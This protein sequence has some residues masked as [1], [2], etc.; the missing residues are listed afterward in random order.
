MVSFNKPD[1]AELKRSWRDILHVGLPAAGTNAIIPVAMT[2]HYRHDRALRT[3]GRGRFWRCQSHRV[4][5]AGY[6]LRAVV[7]HWPVRR[8]K[9]V[10]GK[11]KSHSG[12]AAPLCSFLP[13]QR[14]GHSGAAGG[15]R[16]VFCPPCFSQNPDVTDVTR[17][18][19]WMA[20]ISYGAY[21]VVMV[22]NAAFNGL[23]KPMPAVYISVTRMIA[24]VPAT[25][26]RG[27][28]LVWHRRHIWCL[29]DCQCS[30]RFVE[31]FLGAAHGTQLSDMP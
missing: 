24:H 16:Q 15:C 29:R 4:V 31:L 27:A 28:A 26:H 13:R 1:L 18:F 20:P 25:R 2:V 23:G 22:M 19:L 17:L 30:V 6:F 11:R 14:S 10:G 8:T 9:F 21:G 12:G 5:S 7:G 3:R